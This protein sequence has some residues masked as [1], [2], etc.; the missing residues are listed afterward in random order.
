MPED[1]TSWYAWWSIKDLQVR[2][3]T[4]FM[5]LQD[6]TPRQKRRR[7]WGLALMLLIYVPLMI[8]MWILLNRAIGH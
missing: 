5:R 6:L 8:Y 3:I 1:P 7:F 4:R 2:R